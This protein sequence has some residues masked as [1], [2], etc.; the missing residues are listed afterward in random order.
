MWVVITTAPLLFFKFTLMETDMNLAQSILTRTTQVIPFDMDGTTYYT[1]KFNAL[2]VKKFREGKDHI[3]MAVQAIILGACDEDG[4]PIFKQDQFE[5]LMNLDFEV[6]EALSG[7][8]LKHSGM[9][10]E[11]EVAKN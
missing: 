9:F 5:E 10:K 8:I 2:D 11:R 1:K 3:E 6:L 7:I 4:A